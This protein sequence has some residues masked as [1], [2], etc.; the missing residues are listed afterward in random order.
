MTAYINSKGTTG[1]EL[2]AAFVETLDAPCVP[3]T[4][5]GLHM[6]KPLQD[7]ALWALIEP[8]LPSPKPRRPERC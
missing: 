6:A 3:R 4:G 8:F 5:G 7:D 1:T 2:P